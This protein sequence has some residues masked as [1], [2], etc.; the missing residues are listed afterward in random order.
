MQE[1]K[2]Q[3]L[4][5]KME[6]EATQ[7]AGQKQVSTPDAEIPNMTQLKDVIFEDFDNIHF[8]SLANTGPSNDNL[9]SSLTEALNSLEGAKWHDALQEELNLLKSN[10]IYEE[11]PV[12]KGVMHLKFNANRNVP[13]HKVRIVARGFAQK[14]GVNYQEV[15]ALV[16]NLKS[17][18]IIMALVAKYDLELDQ[19]DITGTYLNGKLEEELYMHPPEGVNIKLGYC[20]QLH[21][22]LYGLKQAGRTWN[23]MLDRKLGELHFMHLDAKTCLYVHKEKNQLCF[24]VVYVDDLLLA[25]T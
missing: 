24:L 25:A 23:K 8:A 22:S 14:E 21:R 17:V 18:R 7:L 1:E 9:P 13:H 3:R 15:F 11:V 16:T 19:M 12:L 4:H 20:W 6:Q 10:N 5:H 2:Q